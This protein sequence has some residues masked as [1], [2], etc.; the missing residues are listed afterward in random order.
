MSMCLTTCRRTLLVSAINSHYTE[1][2]EI[3]VFYL[4]FTQN[5]YNGENRIILHLYVLN[6]YI[7]NF[8]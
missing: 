5:L 7:T 2:D 8:F 1:T 6:Y 3:F 4:T